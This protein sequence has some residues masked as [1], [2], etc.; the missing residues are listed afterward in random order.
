MQTDKRQKKGSPT[1]IIR[2][3][4]VGEVADLLGVCKNTVRSWTESGVLKSYRIGRRRDRQIPSDAVED[5]IKEGRKAKKSP[6]GH[7]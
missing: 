5:F 1:S 3:L 4:R 6:R 7:S 2:P